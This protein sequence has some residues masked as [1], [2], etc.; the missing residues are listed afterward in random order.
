MKFT[1]FFKYVSVYDEENI[2]KNLKFLTEL[3]LRI[4]I[5]FKKVIIFCQI[6]KDF[7]ILESEKSSDDLFYQNLKSFMTENSFF[8]T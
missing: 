3:F 5:N 6:L 7:K 4:M 1:F 8:P 2:L